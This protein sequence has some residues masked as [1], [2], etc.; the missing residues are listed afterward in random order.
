MSSSRYTDE[1]LTV[2]QCD[3]ILVESI[4][5]RP[6]DVQYNMDRPHHHQ[7]KGKRRASKYTDNTLPFTQNSRNSSTE[8][9]T[10]GT[11]AAAG[12]W[13]GRSAGRRDYTGERTRGGDSVLTHTFLGWQF[14]RLTH[15]KT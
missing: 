7:V 12:T 2:Y 9:A 6:A 15:V 11:L 1:E 5:E 14:H 8:T 3:G 4:K 13:R 10:E